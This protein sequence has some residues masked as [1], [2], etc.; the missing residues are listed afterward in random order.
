MR[1]VAFLLAIAAAT[2]AHAASYGDASIKVGT[3]GVIWTAVLPTDG[4]DFSDT[5]TFTLGTGSGTSTRFSASFFDLAVQKNDPAYGVLSLP[6][7]TFT[8]NS[9]DKSVV[10]TKV[11]PGIQGTAQA[12][13]SFSGLTAETAYTLTVA[14]KGLG[15]NAGTG[16]YYLGKTYSV[17]VAAVPEPET[18]AMLVAGL[19]L[20]G[21]VARRRRVSKA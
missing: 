5:F 11:A 4:A 16:S 18:Y 14:G 1:K 17:N 19:G 7:I 12:A 10:A 8:L 2:S 15:D 21:A 9:I 6:E 3:G 20:L 13:V